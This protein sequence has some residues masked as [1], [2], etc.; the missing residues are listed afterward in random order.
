MIYK[1]LFPRLPDARISVE[2]I[3]RYTGPEHTSWHMLRKA[4]KGCSTM[5]KLEALDGWLEANDTYAARI[6]VQ[7]YLN[8][9]KR[10]GQ[11]SVHG[12]ILK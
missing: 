1:E 4:I 3:R 7:N 5:T 6:Q 9:L 8:A 12:A 11:L 10:G 2:D